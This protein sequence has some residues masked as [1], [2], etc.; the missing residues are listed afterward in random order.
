MREADNL[1]DALSI[2]R[3]ACC[4]GVLALVLS[5]PGLFLIL[6]DRA[7]MARRL[8][9]LSF[10]FYLARGLVWTQAWQRLDVPSA[11]NDQGNVLRR[12]VVDA[13]E[14]RRPR[15]TSPFFIPLVLL[16]L[17]EFLDH[18]KGPVAIGLAILSSLSLL[19]IVIAEVRVA[20]AK[21]WK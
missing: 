4:A 8:L 3:L 20:W 15:Y 2:A 5:V 1:S 19:W 17:L 18:E 10:W 7:D 13:I 6:A 12:K 14:W 11:V 16:G 9:N 21:P